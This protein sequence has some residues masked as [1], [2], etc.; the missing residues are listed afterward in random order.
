MA[1]RAVV[2]DMGRDGME[3][4]VELDPT[5]VSEVEAEDSE[6][7]TPHR[8][9]SLNPS[10]IPLSV[11][12]ITRVSCSRRATS[13]TASAT[14]SA[15]RDPDPDPDPDPGRMRWRAAPHRPSSPA[16]ADA[17]ADAVAVA[18]DGR[19]EVSPG[20]SPRSADRVIRATATR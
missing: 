8:T 20:D 19:M 18:D 5:V 16:Q 4:D 12:E 3:L 13:M 14:S 6:T 17:D 1:R 11:S 10:A 15:S 7:A 9:S 2:K